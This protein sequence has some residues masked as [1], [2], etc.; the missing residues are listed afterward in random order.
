MLELLPST[1]WLLTHLQVADDEVVVPVRWQFPLVHSTAHSD[2]DEYPEVF[3]ASGALRYAALHDWPTVDVPDHAPSPPRYALFF[4][5][6]EAVGVWLSCQ[7]WQ[8]CLDYTMLLCVFA[9]V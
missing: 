8:G 1:L 6:S 7:V 9:G 4:D 2:V 5:P 3:H